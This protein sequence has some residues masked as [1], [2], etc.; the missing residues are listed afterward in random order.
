MVSFGSRK[1][2]SQTASGP[3]IKQTVD[4]LNAQ[5]GHADVDRNSGKSAQQEV[6]R[7]NL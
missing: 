7:P 5:V 4:R 2:R 6:C 1:T 3:V